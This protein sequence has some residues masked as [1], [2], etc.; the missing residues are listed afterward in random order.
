[1]DSEENSGGTFHVQMTDVRLLEALAGLE[2]SLQ[3]IITVSQILELT[4]RVGLKIIS[5]EDGAERFESLKR[6]LTLSIQ[7]QMTDQVSISPPKD[8]RFI[9]G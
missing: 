1:M 4:V 3:S 7:D 8:R 2:L 6:V 5:K 9:S